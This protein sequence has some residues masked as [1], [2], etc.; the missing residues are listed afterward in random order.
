MLLSI[1][2]PVY[3]IAPYLSATIE[4][5]L[6]QSFRD[7]ELILVD[8]G[9]T[10]GSGEICSRYANADAR[11]RVVRQEN[12]GVSAARN[13]GIEVSAGELIGFVDGDDMISRDMYL[14]LIQIM[15]Q[16]GA[17]I[18]QCN[19]DRSS[20][21]TDSHSTSEPSPYVCVSG[22]E[23][24][25][26]IFAKHGAEYTNQVSLCTKVFK[27][28][29]LGKIHFPEG[30]TYEDEH[31]TYKACYYARQIAVTY[32]ILYHYIKR[33]NSIITGVSPRK[34]LDKQKALYDRM[35]W[36]PA[37]MPGLGRECFSSFMEYSKH[38]S[39]E[40]WRGGHLEHLDSALR[41]VMQGVRGRK[42]YLNAYDRIYIFLLRCGRS[43]S[44]I[45]RNEFS[46]IQNLIYRLRG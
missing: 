45:M 13:R 35:L 15:M 25:S 8:D 33:E 24:V 31:E 28:N 27:R 10:D 18:A 9:S 29:I 19:H 36:L 37:R 17:D 34:M 7:F 30:Q 2:I 11:V 42:A 32:D 26:R 40:L 4:S 41:L 5:V 6:N 16:S 43:K 39:C 12:Q 3:N 38:I 44:W 20:D 22:P 21:S 14:R 1:I 23:F 46:P